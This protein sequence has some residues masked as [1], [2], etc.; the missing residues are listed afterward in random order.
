[1]ARTVP[2]NFSTCDTDDKGIEVG[3][4]QGSEITSPEKPFSLH[5]SLA[6]QLN[7]MKGKVEMTKRYSFLGPKA[8]LSDWQQKALV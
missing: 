2:V 8:R 4:K 5:G 3:E 6:L 7:L 1:M